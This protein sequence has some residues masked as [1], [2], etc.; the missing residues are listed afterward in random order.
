MSTSSSRFSATERHLLLCHPTHSGHPALSPRCPLRDTCL[1]DKTTL[2]AVPGVIRLEDKRG[3][4]P[5]ST[6]ATATK[7]VSFPTRAVECSAPWG[8]KTSG[9]QAWQKQTSLKMRSLQP[10]DIIFIPRVNG[11]TKIFHAES[12]TGG[13][14]LLREGRDAAFILLRNRRG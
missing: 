14:L 12:G 7:P 3:Q 10:P 4:D 13:Y 11:R 2:T 5:A 6:V 1:P 8:S 9:L